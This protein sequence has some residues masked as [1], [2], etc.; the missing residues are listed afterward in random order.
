[1][2]VLR[3]RYILIFQFLIFYDSH[4]Q[5][6]YGLRTLKALESTWQ[7]EVS[8]LQ[9]RAFEFELPFP[10]TCALNTL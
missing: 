8:L 3:A 9:L 10:A 1:M 5:R 2:P 4:R 6:I 7:L